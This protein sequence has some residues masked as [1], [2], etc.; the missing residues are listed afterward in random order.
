MNLVKKIENNSEKLDELLKLIQAQKNTTGQK[1]ILT[2]VETMELL[3]IN[4]NT[5][6]NWRKIGFI[7]VYSMNRR[8]YTKYS[9]IMQSLENGLLERA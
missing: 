9:E 2:A 5:F 6:A 7:K 3:K 4:R 8:L 1:E